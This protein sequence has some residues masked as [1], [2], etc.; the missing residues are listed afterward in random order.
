MRTW[1]VYNVFVFVRSGIPQ[2]MYCTQQNIKEGGYFKGWHK[3]TLFVG[4][5]VNTSSAKA[6]H[7]V[8]YTLVFGTCLT[9]AADDGFYNNL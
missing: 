9:P 4:C 5:G 6:C 3:P 1:H 2:C 8:T 7:R